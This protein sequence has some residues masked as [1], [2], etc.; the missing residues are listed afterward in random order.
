M[1]LI[2][3]MQ[4]ISE[5]HT[6]VVHPLTLWQAAYLA[7][8]DES[9]VQKIEKMLALLNKL[10]MAMQADVIDYGK[11]DMIAKQWQQKYMGDMNKAAERIKELEDIIKHEKYFIAT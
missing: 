4:M 1:K 10:T 9:G 8:G 6:D 11:E 5:V 7:K 3:R 2:E